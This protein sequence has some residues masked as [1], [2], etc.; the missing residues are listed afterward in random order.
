MP[1]THDSQRIEW[2]VPAG[3]I[4]LS[5]VPAIF[6]TVRL[7]EVAGHAEATAA[8]ARFLAH[9]LPV[10]S[11]ILTAVPY[12]II[13]ALQFA[14]GFRRR[15]RAWHR[16]IGRVLVP[17]SLVVAATGLWMTLVYPWPEGDG[18]GLYLERLLVG[19]AMLTFVMLGVNAIRRRDFVAH[20]AWMLR[21]YAIGL[22]AGTQVLTHL[23]WFILMDEKPG[24]I[25]RAVLMGLAWVLNSMVAEWAIRKRA[26]TK[27]S[28]VL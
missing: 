3:L 6:G 27:G 1:T 20:G 10:V 11:H 4:L 26:L 21:A 19:A 5:L 24:E 28:G 8:N 12:S 2:R 17:V 14:P 18:L 15:H 22:G 16:A 23:P 13:G 9:P 25:S 7:T